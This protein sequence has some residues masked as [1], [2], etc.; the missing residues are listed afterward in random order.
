MT[1]LFLPE[2]ELFESE[3]EGA[4]LAYDITKI[5]FEICLYS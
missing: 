5:H 2:T 4:A 3:L 1:N